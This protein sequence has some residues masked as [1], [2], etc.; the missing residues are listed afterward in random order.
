MITC[1][2]SVIPETVAH[3]QQ[4]AVRVWHDSLSVLSVRF[5]EVLSKGSRGVD[6]REGSGSVVFLFKLES[7]LFRR[8]SGRYCY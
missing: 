2:S 6:A 8:P 1:S 3:M 7:A 5:F 4:V